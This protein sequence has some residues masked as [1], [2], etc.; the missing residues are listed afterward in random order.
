M[1]TTPA[2]SFCFSEDGE[3]AVRLAAGLRCPRCDREL[4]AKDV[5]ADRFGDVVLVCPGCDLNILSVSDACLSDITG[6]K[7]K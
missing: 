4:M 1:N 6:G 2:T 3:R 7:S 5:G